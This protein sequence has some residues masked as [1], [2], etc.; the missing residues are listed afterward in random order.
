MAYTPGK[1][2]KLQLSIASVFT[3]LA[4]VASLTPL[5]MEMSTTE[6]TH[7]QSAARE[8]ISGILDGGEVEFTIEYDAAATTHATLWTKFQAGGKEAWKIIFQDL[9]TAEVAFDGIITNFAWDEVVVDGVV[10][11]ALTI[12]V[13]GLP[14]ITP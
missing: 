10:T 6:V 2:T 9:G 14:V 7:L 8:F 1:N 12:K 3:D 5:S 11:A 13:T 4:Q